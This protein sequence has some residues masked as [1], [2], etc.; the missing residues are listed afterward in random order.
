M[1]QHIQYYK[2]FLPDERLEGVIFRDV[3]G[4]HQFITVY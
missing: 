1:G 4:V 2:L 3:Q